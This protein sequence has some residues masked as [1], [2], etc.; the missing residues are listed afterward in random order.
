MRKGGALI[1]FSAICIGLS[2]Q[3]VVNMSDFGV[4][5]GKKDASPA[6]VKALNAISQKYG[7][8]GIT[9]VFEKGVY[10]FHPEKALKKEYYISNHD[11]DNP[12]S[13]GLDFDGWRNLTIE[14]N[15]AEFLF[16]GRMLP[17]AIVNSYG[18]TLKDFRIDFANPHIAQVTI[19]QSSADGIV[20][21]P[22]AWVKSR[23][24]KKGRFITYGDGWE[25]S[26]M[27]GIAFE[28]DTRHMVFNTRDLW[29]RVDSIIKMPDGALYAPKWKDSR[30]KPGTVVALRT[31]KRP[32]PGI[33]LSLDTATHINNVTVHYAEG[34]GLLA[35]MCTDVALD[36]FN[37]CLRGDDDA[38]YFTTQADATH[39]SGCKGHIDSR[40]GLYEGMMDDAINIHGT[41]LKVTDRNGSRT[42]TAR[43]MHPQAYGFFWGQ[44][45]DSV[46]FIASSTMEVTGSP[47]V[48]ASITPVD[49]PT[50]DGAKEFRITFKDSVPA[51]INPEQG[52]G[53]ENLTWSP[54]ATFD[55]NTIRNNRARGSLFSTPR[56]T[57]ITNNTFDH[58]SGTAILLCGD[59]NGWFETGACRDVRI[60]GNRFINALTNIFQ[61][62][63][64]VISI[65]PEIP[66]LEEQTRYFHGGPGYPGIIIT[67]N[68]FEAFDHPILFA[69]SI[70][71]LT[72]S[73]NEIIKTTDYP[74]FHPNKYTFK[75]MNARNVNISDNTFS[76]P[77]EV[78]IRVE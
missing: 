30:L 8:E 55:R 64:G 23:I 59:C 31:W 29:C 76:N 10:N 21:R 28:G 40:N 32:T 44:E 1:L 58:T 35:Q 57:L 20:F 49:K 19:E 46:Q 42:L 45:G 17:I 4:R 75:L 24:D 67:G 26:P 7:T 61:F 13:L 37:V 60:E 63:E 72:F 41:Y 25:L 78:S 9:L 69:K 2:G 27:N 36:G 3:T 18:C 68:K 12:K 22:A 77:D 73:G 62:S 54:T 39:F 50:I 52:Y 33:F 5:P 70:D 16:H 14:G 48:I 71:G 65:Y 34:M 74:M 6:M 51:E 11:Q 66:H 53:I 47:N 15:G 43:Y 38:R 56:K